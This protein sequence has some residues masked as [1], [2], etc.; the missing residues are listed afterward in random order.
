M[1]LNGRVIVDVQIDGVDSRDYPDFADAHFSYAVYQDTH[2]ELTDEELEDLAN[3]YPEELYEMA[4][5][6]FVD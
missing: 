2:E 3:G 4:Y 1:K 5:Q 6:H